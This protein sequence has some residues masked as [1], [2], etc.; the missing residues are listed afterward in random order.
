MTAIPNSI[1]HKINVQGSYLSVP[2]ATFLI[3][4]FSNLTADPS[5]HYEGQTFLGS[6][7]VTTDAN[8][9]ATFAANL[10]SS[11]ASSSF[12]T[13]TATSLSAI[14]PGLTAGD[15]SPFSAA[16]LSKAVSVQ[17]AT[18][19]FT[20][21]SSAQA[22]TI[23][24]LR[25]GNTSAAVSVN[26]ATSNGTAIAGRNYA[27]AAGTL[28]FQPGQTLQTFT[29]TILPNT[30]E[31]SGSATINLAL[32]QPMGGA[33]LGSISTATLTIDLAPGPPPTPFDATFPTVTSEQLVV[34]GRAITAVTFTFS[35]ALNPTRARDLGNYG[36]YVFSA[37]YHYTAGAT[38][39]PLSSAVY[40]P[41]AS[42][43]TLY[44]SSPLPLNKFFQITIDGQASPLLN[45]GLT[46][47]AG[48]QLAGSG[49]APGT[50]LV[51]TF[52][53]GTK[54]SYIDGG[55]NAVSLQLTKG[56][57]MEMF[58]SPV[59]VVEQLQLVS[60][61]ARKSILDGSVRRGRGGTGRAFLPSIGG[62]AGVKIR[63]KTPPFYF[64]ATPPI[65][66]R[67]VAKPAVKLA[68]KSWFALHLARRQRH[69]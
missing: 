20:I 30:T 39:T 47:L 37:G 35:K 38:Y 59:G 50:P 43:V 2:F 62:S 3:Q 22:A 19:G 48:N 68:P 64:G 41:T 16:I 4:L 46:D 42:T 57:L 51:V 65:D 32:S 17:F 66:A 44:P 67:I 34:T 31:S 69:T 53:V 58:I 5:G 33:A 23:N 40:N 10:T 25:T 29:V 36:F 1:T 15:S 28:S 12:I 56:G 26:Y 52:A 8:G 11:V 14:E 21:S 61:I 9:S 24:V 54:L 13:A 6:T 60:T 55:N 45:N 63:L 49:G 27:A 7:I 18:A